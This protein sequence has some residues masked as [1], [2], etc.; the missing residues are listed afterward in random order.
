MPLA[1]VDK[2]R[3]HFALFISALVVSMVLNQQVSLA[4]TAP[5]PG[6]REALLESLNRDIKRER[7]E[8][9]QH[10]QNIKEDEKSLK[11]LRKTLV[12]V[13]KN[14]QNAERDIIKIQA[15]RDDLQKKHDSLAS[16]LEVEKASLASMVM[17]LQRLKRVPP[18][19]VLIKPGSPLQT[20][21]TSLVLRSTLPAIKK[22]TSDLN[23][24]LNEYQAT[25]TALEEQHKQAKTLKDELEIQNKQLSALLNERQKKYT[26][27]KILLASH[28]RK[29]NNLAKKAKTL[30]ELVSNIKIASQN[31]DI[32]N[33]A[34]KALIS[35]G[36]IP[37][38]GAVQLP[39][40]GIIRTGYNELDTMGARSKGLYIEA[41]DGSLV[42]APMGGQ[43]KFAGAFK[44]FGNLVILEHRSGY[45][46]LIG[47]LKKVTV[48][49][50]QLIVSG[51]P[52]GIL[53]GKST[54]SQRSSLYF[55]LRRGGNAINPSVKF[56]DLG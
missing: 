55:E 30:K 15:L 49:V 3:L 44:N 33:S 34:R 13:S 7:T 24:L 32:K 29:V 40:S 26:R 39:I 19:T 9:R 17:A 50:G 16:D 10:Q 46:S 14:I 36:K 31:E 28:V 43:V 4:K 47:G 8:T 51:E 1:L 23:A 5:R 45:H 20:A 53:G 54:S 12:K 48:N 38:H 37:G 25:E 2:Q 42:V 41:H 56:S 35:P 22:K 11:E 52:L 6:S 27:N 21:Q 18:E